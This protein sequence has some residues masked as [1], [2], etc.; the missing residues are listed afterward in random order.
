MGWSLI[1]I[2]MDDYHHCSYTV[3]ISQLQ[4]PDSSV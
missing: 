2:L 1:Y 3:R 4:S